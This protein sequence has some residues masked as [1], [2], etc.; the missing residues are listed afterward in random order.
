MPPG[1]AAVS[2]IVD[3]SKS[4]SETNPRSNSPQFHLTPP[5]RQIPDSIIVQP[6]Q[7]STTQN[8]QRDK[9]PKSP[10]Y[11]YDSELVFLSK[12]LN[13][14]DEVVPAAKRIIA[15]VKADTDFQILYRR[16]RKI[17]FPLVTRAA[18]LGACRQLGVPKTFRELEIDLTQDE[19]LSFHRVFKLID[20]ILKKY[21]LSSRISEK[22]S[23][24]IP[25]L[26]SVRDFVVSQAKTLGLS[27]KI[28]NRALLISEN[29]DVQNLFSGKQPN[30]AAAVVLEFS[31]ACEK[32]YLAVVDYARV[33]NVSVST[34]ALS[35]KAFCKFLQD[36]YKRGKLPLIFHC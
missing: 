28:L 20:S 18:I 2:S 25:S 6:L 4:L 23:H 11:L 3:T 32:Y 15:R 34:L 7:P 17:T 22:E 31:A 27:D 26:F 24:V 19:K 35:R 8:I 10:D 5:P 14:P 33:A 12:Q 13:L 16:S 21:A 1:S 36:M 9:I 29:R 30:A